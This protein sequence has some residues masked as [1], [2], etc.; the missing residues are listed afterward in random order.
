[1]IKICQGRKIVW[2]CSTSRN[3]VLPKIQNTPSDQR[4]YEPEVREGKY[5][6]VK[7]LI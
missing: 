7:M 2:P 6:N 5:T 4:T 1:M 3:T